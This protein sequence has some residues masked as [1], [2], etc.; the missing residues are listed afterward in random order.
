MDFTD[1][2]NPI[3]IAYFDRGP[4]LKD[5]LILGA[6]GQLITMKVIFMVQ[7]LKEV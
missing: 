4:I 3:E 1:S 6:T 7:K 5:L 2:S